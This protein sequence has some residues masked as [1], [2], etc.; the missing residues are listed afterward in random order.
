MI[1]VFPK[2]HAYATHGVIIPFLS[3][4]SVAFGTSIMY[5]SHKNIILMLY[6]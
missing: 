3:P 4:S 6:A 1:I 5:F 2:A